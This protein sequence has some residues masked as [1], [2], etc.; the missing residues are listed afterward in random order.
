MD[1]ERAELRRP[2][3]IGC[4]DWYG[5]LFRFCSTI[6]VKSS[7]WT[8]AITDLSVGDHTR[9]HCLNL[10]VRCRSNHHASQIVCDP[11]HEQE[12]TPIIVRPLSASRCTSETPFLNAFLWYYLSP[13]THILNKRMYTPNAR[14]T[15]A[16][17]K[18]AAREAGLSASSGIGCSDLGRSV[19]GWSVCGRRRKC[20]RLQERHPLKASSSHPKKNI[21][22]PVNFRNELRMS[23]SVSP[24][25]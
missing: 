20:H 15:H 19:H 1:R 9:S 18:D 3:G 24:N 13:N 6:L 21:A 4:T 10:S 11:H 8:K 16:G 17:P 14:I 2:S 22:A 12:S 5:P 23:V 25:K 7:I